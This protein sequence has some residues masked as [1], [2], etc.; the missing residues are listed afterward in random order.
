MLTESRLSSTSILDGNKDDDDDDHND[1]PIVASEA[2]R[3]ATSRN[4]RNN[5]KNGV[6]NDMLIHLVTWL[7][8]QIPFRIIVIFEPSWEVL[9]SI[10]I[11]AFCKCI[12]IL[13][14]Y[15]GIIH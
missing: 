6:R 4:G 10:K 5:N 9:R 7:V 3:N 2:I 15:S 13:C 12:I 11:K 14:T 1:D 8:K